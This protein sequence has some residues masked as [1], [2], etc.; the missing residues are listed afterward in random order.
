MIRRV[1]WCWV[2]PG[3]YNGSGDAKGQFVV[4]GS[5]NWCS[6]SFLRFNGNRD[7]FLNIY[8]WKARMKI[9]FRSGPRSRQTAA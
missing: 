7:L 2:Q 5:S 9:S 3:T 8:N 6:N 1:R 4:I